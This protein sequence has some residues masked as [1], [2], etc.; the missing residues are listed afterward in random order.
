MIGTNS[1]RD[2][3]LASITEFNRTFLRVPPETDCHPNFRIFWDYWKSKF[4][5]EQFP[6]RRDLDPLDIP[7]LLSSIVIVDVERDPYRFRYRLTG[8][9]ISIIHGLKLTNNYVDELRPKLL[10]EVSQADLVE[11][12]E[13][14]KPQ[15]VELNFENR[16]KVVRSYKVLR[17]PLATDN[18]IDHIMVWTDYQ[19]A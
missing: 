14:K 3:P 7:L 9:N 18:L 2:F 19:T 15:F 10:S 13:K 6:G 12:V 8:E 5:G 1:S 11:L 17:L 16:E 4:R